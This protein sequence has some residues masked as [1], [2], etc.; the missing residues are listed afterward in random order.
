M[1]IQVIKFQIKAYQILFHQ[2][3]TKI[4][5]YISTGKIAISNFETGEIAES[6]KRD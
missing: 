2:T 4:I 5:L 1:G 6:G 3:Y